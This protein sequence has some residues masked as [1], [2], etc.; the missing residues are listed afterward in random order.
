[1]QHK[2]PEN[3][4]K[5]EN[6]IDYYYFKNGMIPTNIEI[7][8]GTSLS[9]ATVSRYISKMNEMG[10]LTASGHRNIKTRKMIDRR[11]H[12]KVPIVL[13]SEVKNKKEGEILLPLEL[14]EEGDCILFLAE[15]D[16][17]KDAGIL[18]GD[19]MLVR[20]Q[21]KVEIG[22][23]VLVN[24]NSENVPFRLLKG[25]GNIIRLHPENEKMQ[26]IYCTSCDIK[27]IVERVVKKVI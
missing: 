21:E 25:S 5:I 7:S 15:S 1:M 20:K 14:M 6:Y 16:S 26:D 3:Y 24:I 22:S 12:I 11:M 19:L 4:E 18:K 23:I 27:G 17:M 13:S 8:K 2:N 9:T 10:I